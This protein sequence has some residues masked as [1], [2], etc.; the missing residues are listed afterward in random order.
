[1]WLIPTSLASALASECSTKALPQDCEPS[2]SGLALWVTSSGTPTLRQYSWRGWQARRWSRHLFGPGTLRRSDGNSLLAAW[3]SSARDSRANRTPWP[4]PEK[5]PTTA[6]GY[7]RL[8]QTA[9]AWFDPASSSWKTSP[10]C[11]LLGE[12]LPYSQTWP[13]SGFVSNGTASERPTWAP[14]ISGSGF[15]SSPWPTPD[16]TNRVRDEETMAKCAAFRKRKA[17]Q[18]T[19]PLYLAERA[20]RWATPDCNTSTRSNGLMGPNIREQAANWP[21]PDVCSASRDMSKIDQDRQKTANGKVTIGLP[22]IA[23]NW[24]TPAARDDQKSPDAYRHMREHKLGRTGAA[25]ETISSLSVKV[26]TWPTP[27]SR[28]QKGEN[29]MAHMLRTDGRTDGRIHHIDQLP[30]FVM[31]HFSHQD[32]TMTNGKTSS[33]PIQT[34]PRQRLNPNFVDWLMG[35]P[36]GMTN[37]EPTACDAE[38]MASWRSKLDWHLSSLLGEQGLHREAA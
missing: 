33:P 8:S 3:T 4:E 22:T 34:S 21:T 29:S 17:N 2:E 25:A 7:G 11:D 9:F 24:P 38:A 14:P 31:F 1:M 32:Q 26:Q 37:T 13:R 12:W 15:S 10:G 20:Q 6:A 19:V 23:E 16:A 35:W 5:E 28:D 18:N 30:N 36:P 27:T